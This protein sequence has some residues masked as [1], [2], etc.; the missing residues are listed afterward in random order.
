MTFREGDDV[1]DPTVVCLGEAGAQESCQKGGGALMEKGR[2]PEIQKAY[3]SSQR[4]YHSL[5]IPNN[6]KKHT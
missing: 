1:N 6:D 2:D 5:Y 4:A 3:L